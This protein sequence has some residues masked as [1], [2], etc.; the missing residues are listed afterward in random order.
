MIEKIVLDY[1][2]DKLDVETHT[3]EHEELESYVLIE[4]TGGGKNNHIFSGT[5]AIKSY[6]PTMFKA[7]SLN[8]EVKE[9]MEHIVDF[10]DVVKCKL[11]TDYNFTDISKKKYRYQA[12]F[13]LVHY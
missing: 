2:N 3:E 1:L 8:E 11:M 9:A 5:L 10:T 12:V 4:K 13:D 7:S 6:A